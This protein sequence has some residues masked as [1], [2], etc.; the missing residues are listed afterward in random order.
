MKYRQGSIG[1]VFVAKLEHGDDFLA[2]V[3]KLAVQENIRS[4]TFFMIGALRSASTVVGPQE[5]VLPPEP[6]WRRFDDARELVGVGTIFSDGGEPLIH[7]HA[8]FGK[9]D[10]TLMG[11]IRSGTEVYLVLEVIIL[12]IAGTGAKRMFDEKLNLKVLEFD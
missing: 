7:V 5:P 4:A 8:A 12:E 9:G 2:E 10:G 1:R 3:K 6:V 11:C